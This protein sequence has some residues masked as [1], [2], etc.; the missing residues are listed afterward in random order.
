MQQYLQRVGKVQQVLVM[1]A[2][3][4]GRRRIVVPKV[5]SQQSGQKEVR[6]QPS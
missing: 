2:Q 5:M 6:L 1:V 4:Q 3:M